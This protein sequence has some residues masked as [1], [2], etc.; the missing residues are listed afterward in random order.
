MKHI[1]DLVYIDDYLAKVQYLN[2]AG[3]IGTSD[4][5][6]YPEGVSLDE[7]ELYCFEINIM[8][9]I[10]NNDEG[11]FDFSKAMID[12]GCEIGTYSFVLPFNFCYMFDGNRE[13]CVLAEMNM[14]LHNKLDHSKCF[15]T[16]L[17]DKIETVKYDGFCSEF[18]PG[19]IFVNYEKTKSEKVLCSTLDSYNLNNIG[20]IKID[21]EG[22]E[23]KVLRGGIGT[24]IRNNYPPILFE[25]WEVNSLNYGMKEEKY[26]ALIKFLTDLG[27][28]I[29]YEWGDSRTHLAI[30]K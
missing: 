1:K 11:Y 30:H 19:S 18:T 27:Y 5:Y 8:I 4:N 17:S 20:F 21:V 26:Q 14:L 16:L 29:L 2:H 7:L 23:E 13:K 15:N 9:K 10:S 22:M 12:I 6:I 28:E 25:L 24:I 3:Y